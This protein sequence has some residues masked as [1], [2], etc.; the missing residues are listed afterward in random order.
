MASGALA[1]VIMLVAGGATAAQA[2]EKFD[3]LAIVE[4]QGLLQGKLQA[5]ASTLKNS[6]KQTDAS[7]EASVG[8][9][10]TA[11]PVSIAP[12]SGSKS[13]TVDR[14]GAEVIHEDGYGFVTGTGTSGTNASFVV[15]ENE[16]APDAFAFQI[17]DPSTTLTLVDDGSALVLNGSGE[18]VNYLAKPWA[19]DAA[20]KELP[21]HYTVNG[22]TITQHVDTTG[23]QFPVVAD[24]T[25]GCGFGWC[26]VYFNRAETNGI[27]AG[28]AVA[29]GAACA[30]LN[31]AA[32]AAC[33]VVSGAIVVVAQGANA[34]GNCVGIV[35]YGVPG[36]LAGWNPFVE[37]RGTSHC[38]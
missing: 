16:T 6:M 21:T 2:T 37:P 19:R 7:P 24:P 1:A 35:G 32:G 20:G 17:G 34:N 15:I 30:Q 36:A 31:P 27:A 33:A 11:Q 26:S 23:A 29:A 5:Q 13:S 9:A 18:V 12:V 38:P 10:T 28:G 22:N 25:T 8:G 4:A 14:L 3:P